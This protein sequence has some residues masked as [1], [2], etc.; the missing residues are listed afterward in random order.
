M[1]EQAATASYHPFLR[2][3]GLFPAP[4]IWYCLGPQNTLNLHLDFAE[5]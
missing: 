3:E 4:S 5:V 2:G 1:G